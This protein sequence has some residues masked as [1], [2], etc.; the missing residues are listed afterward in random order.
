VTLEAA[1]PIEQLVAVAARHG[2]AT[3]PV[4]ESDGRFVG[5]L[6][7][8][9][10]QRALAEKEGER[11]ARDIAKHRDYAVADESLLRAVSRMTRLGVRQLPVLERGTHRLV[12]MLAMSDVM[13]AQMRVEGGDASTSGMDRPTLE[14]LPGA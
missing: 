7:E 5:L 1:M 9:R 3:Y 8:A 4:L 10:L 11:P 2:H 12:G 13:R 14:S 6:S